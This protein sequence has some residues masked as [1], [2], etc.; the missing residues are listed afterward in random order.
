MGFIEK[1]RLSNDKSDAKNMTKIL[2]LYSIENDVSDIEA[3]EI[4]S[5]VNQDN[6]YIFIPR[7]DDYSFWYDK[8]NKTISLKSPYEE[9]NIS[10]FTSLNSMNNTSRPM[11]IGL[12]YAAETLQ[13]GDQLEELVQ[14]FLLLDVGGSEVAEAIN[15]I[16]NLKT[17]DDFNR[18]KT[19]LDKYGLGE[20]VEKFSPDNTLYI[21]DFYDVTESVDTVDNVI[22]SDGIE[23]I[24]GGALSTVTQTPNEIK[25]PHSVTYIEKDAF[26]NLPLGTKILRENDI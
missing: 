23:T 24:P 7:T 10:D 8:S 20:H 6:D 4:R 26:S 22:F 14:G 11:N 18:V 25:L 19:V 12:V 9:M 17:V 21:N 16:R 13:S 15:T 3:S 2:Q 5:I 1:A